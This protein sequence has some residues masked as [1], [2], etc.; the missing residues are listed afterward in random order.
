MNVL[1]YTISSFVFITL[2]NPFNKAT[3]SIEG[4]SDEIICKGESITL[5]A[6]GESFDWSNGESTATITVSPDETT[7]YSVTIT[8]GDFECDFSA[9]V[10]VIEITAEVDQV[11]VPIGTEVTFTATAIPSGG[12]FEWTGEV[13]GAT[14]SVT[15][16]LERAGNL[17]NVI[18][19]TYNGETCAEEVKVTVVKLISFSTECSWF[20]EGKAIKKDVFDIVTD[21]VD[22]EDI[23]I[24]E[25]STVTG[26]GFTLPIP[27]K[28]P[29]GKGSLEVKM[30]CGTS[31]AKL[32]VDVVNENAEIEYIL[33]E[34]SADL[35]G[36][37]ASIGKQTNA[38][39]AQPKVNGK[40]SLK[41]T[42]K[43]CD[44]DIKIMEGINGSFSCSFGPRQIGPTI[45]IFT[46]YP[47]YFEVQ[48]EIG[49]SA[50]LSASSTQDCDNP[51][52]WC[53]GLGGDGTVKIIGAACVGNCN[54]FRIEVSGSAAITLSGT[55]CSA[56]GPNWKFCI[57]SLQYSGSIIVLDSWT[58]AT[59]NG[60]LPQYS[61]C[62]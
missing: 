31:N 16:D 50:S 8:D 10:E 42:P 22:N 45:R 52:N 39:G 33:K 19:Y 2:L 37:L 5:T 57:A 7:T 30:K 53:G 4:P 27:P 47:V 20:V 3:A 58:I 43:K 18:E 38:G 60:S 61:G 49:A 44:C 6:V 21:P 34:V 25:T 15:G 54:V 35:K 28:N 9:E 17:K 32:I 26:S 29:G 36:L 41:I 14:P 23:V 48:L 24:L 62:W 55:Y 12:T 56:A 13:I 59:V 11:K 46:P 1:K 51:D 40:L